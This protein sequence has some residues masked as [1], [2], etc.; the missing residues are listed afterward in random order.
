MPSLRTSGLV[1]ALLTLK[2][3]W[4]GYIRRVPCPCNFLPVE[5]LDRENIV[6]AIFYSVHVRKNGTL[7]W[8]AFKPS[9]G[10]DEIS[11]MRLDYMT[12]TTCKRKAK[13]MENPPDK[14]YRGLVVLATG[15]VRAKGMAVTDSRCEYCGHAHIS[16]GV[17]FKSSSVAEP[18]D[19]AEIENMK[20]RAEELLLISKYYPDSISSS[21]DWPRD[22]ALVPPQGF[23]HP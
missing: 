23:L 17:S 7:K 12:P 22:I 18:P 15:A 16:T 2:A 14:L 10:T 4:D 11:V 9:Q 13:G 3:V 19:P 1:K 6:R 21:D 20:A 5:V 8:Q